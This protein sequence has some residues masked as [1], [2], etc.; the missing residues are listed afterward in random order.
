MRRN[1]QTKNIA[2]AQLTRIGDVVQTWQAARALK[3]DHPEARL[4]LIARKAMAQGLNF[5]LEGTFEE[6]LYVDVKEIIPSK[7]TALK[8]S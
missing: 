5:L 7:N 6:I 2:I 3:I 1:N 4:F 8:E